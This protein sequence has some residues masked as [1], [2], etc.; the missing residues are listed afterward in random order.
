MEQKIP[1]ADRLLKEARAA[2]V[3]AYAP[4]SGIRVA[5]VVLAGSGQSYVGSNIEN[6]SY[7][8]TICAERSSLFHALVHGE[9]EFIAMVVITDSE[10]VTSPCGSCRQVLAEF[11]PEMPIVFVNPQ[12]I[13]YFTVA[14]L[15]PNTFSLKHHE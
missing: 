1:E 4:Y 10:R 6:S 2:L 15:L 7:S 13:K 14:E 3:N 9:N 12:G 5:A 8:L 11:A